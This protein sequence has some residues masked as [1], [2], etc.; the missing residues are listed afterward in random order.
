MTNNEKVELL[1][2]MEISN[3]P[4]LLTNLLGYDIKIEDFK[5]S[6]QGYVDITSNELKEHTGIM[7]EYYETFRVES[8]SNGFTEDSNIYWVSM[9]FRF[10]YKSGGSNGHTFKNVFY[11][12]KTKTWYTLD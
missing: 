11:N 3:L 1:K 9:S 4:F 12:F 5:I 6:K 2:T 10:R 7:S 8:F